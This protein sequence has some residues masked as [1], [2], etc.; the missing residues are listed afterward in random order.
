MEKACFGGGCFWCTEAIFRRV[1]GVLNVTVG[2][3]GGVDETPTY[4]EVCSGTTGHAEVILIEYDEH[5]VSFDKLLLLFFETHDPTQLNR[6]GSDIGTQYRSVIF[7]MNQP[8]KEISEH[9]IKELNK[10]LYFKKPIVTTIEP[11]N[12]F[13]PAEHYHQ[14]YYAN[15]KRTPYCQFVIAPKIKNLDQKVNKI[16]KM[17]IS[18]SED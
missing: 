15:N 18:T 4:D 16:K 17:K 14:D 13:Y 7:P 11:Y 8:Q 6:Q 2:Y 5:R 9:I 1:D 3:A 10:H 12:E